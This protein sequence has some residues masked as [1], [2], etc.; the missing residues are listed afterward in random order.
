MN[1][2]TMRAW[3]YAIAELIVIVNAILA[4][5]GMG[6]LPFDKAEFLEWAS[7]ALGLAGFVH[8]CWKNHNWTPAAQKAQEFLKGFK[9]DGFIE[10]GN[11]DVK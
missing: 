3:I 2:E 4:A 10:G 8:A 7:Y 6:P 11:T 5:K 9:E 1:K